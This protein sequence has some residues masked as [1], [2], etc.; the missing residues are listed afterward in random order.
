MS[1]KLSMRKL[2]RSYP[3]L[4]GVLIALLIAGAIM[5]IQIWFPW[6]DEA[7]GRHKRLAQ[8]V[9]FTAVYFAI[10]IYYLWRWQRQAAFWP[11]IFVLFLLH[12]LGVY[13]YSAHVQP[14]LLWQWAIVGL[15]E[16][17]AA[18]FFLYWSTRRFG[19]SDS[20]EG[21]RLGREGGPR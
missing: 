6:I 13:F 12:V 20:H 8:A 15:L 14:I 18:A 16:Y 21:P 2:I 5:V 7:L 9:F 11:T 4:L 1:E 10:Y 19:H 17:Y 3:I